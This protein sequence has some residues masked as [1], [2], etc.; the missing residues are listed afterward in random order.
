MNKIILILCTF[1][2][3]IGV[4]A[5]ITAGKT[6]D[7]EIAMI[8]A[9]KNASDYEVMFA[10]FSKSTSLEKWRSYYYSAVAQYLKTES[11]LKKSS[12]QALFESNALALKYAGSIVGAQPNNADVKVLVG[13][14]RLQ[15]IHLDNSPDVQKDK[16]LIIKI[17]SESEALSPDNPR[18]TLLKAGMAAKFSDLK[19]NSLNSDQLYAKAA[20]DFETETSP[21]W[22]RQL[23]SSIK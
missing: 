2:A 23:I 8:N 18:L 13:L 5:Q 19:F 22:G 17:I 11:L 21:N 1:V 14:A 15:R 3:S 12:N 10:K 6:A 16:E 20:K 4:S 7:N 9:A